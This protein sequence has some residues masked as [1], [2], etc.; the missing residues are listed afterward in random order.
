M[1]QH[2]VL[3]I[4]LCRWADALLKL[5][6]RGCCAQ[7]GDSIAINGHKRLLLL[8][9]PEDEIARRGAAWK[10]PVSRYTRGVLA[11]YDADVVGLCRRGDQTEGRRGDC[12]RC[13]AGARRHR[14]GVVRNNGPRES[15]GLFS[16][17]CGYRPA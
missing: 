8:N 3:V 11:K 7:E 12:D 13:G 2:R 14:A 15:A 10:P 16:S 5:R 17:W 4:C 6:L 1:R 9:V